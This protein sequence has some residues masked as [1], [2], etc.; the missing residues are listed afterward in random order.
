VETTEAIARLTLNRP[1]RYNAFDP[2]LIRAL[3]Q[4]FTQTAADE[5]VHGLVVTGAGKAFCAGG[6]VAS[7]RQ[8]LDED[9]K[10]LFLELTGELHPLV[11]AMRACP[12]PVVAAVN[13]PVAG[14]GLGVALACDWRVAAPTASFKPAYAKLGIVPD[15]GA[16]F[17]L[18]RLVGWGHANRIILADAT[19]G[20]EEAQRIGLVDQVVD[21]DRLVASAQERAAR[22][23]S[24]PPQTFA[25]T[26]ALLNETHMANLDG[27][28]ARERELNAASAARPALREGVT[29]FFEKRDPRFRHD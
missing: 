7:M 8:A 20:A 18:P 22:L 15:G 13:G 12:K 1:D 28:L 23:A 3:R 16:S 29:A 26:K 2:A 5:A 10:A 27:Q 17:F 9:P 4:A 25:E 6:D 21:G 19:V 11:K 14:G 24:L